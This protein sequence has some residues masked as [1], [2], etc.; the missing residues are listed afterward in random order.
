MTI[1]LRLLWRAGQSESG[2]STMLKNFQLY[3]TPK[4]LQAETDA[5][6]AVIHLN[7][8]RSVNFVLDVL[9]SHTAAA[10]TQPATYN[11]ATGAAAGVGV[12]LGAVT[13]PSAPAGDAGT[14][15]A[16]LRTSAPPAPSSASFSPPPTA[17]GTSEVRRY[18]LE[19]VFGEA[20]TAAFYGV[21]FYDEKNGLG[22]PEWQAGV[23]E[24]SMR[25]RSHAA[26]PNIR[27][28][29]RLVKVA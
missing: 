14:A 23:T 26:K 24:W 29:W 9:S 7:L 4:A 28:T 20:E 18:K 25:I 12:D 13:A 16:A 2:K 27:R 1:L 17:G 6:R 19:R 15:P 11:P 5:W 8:V 21:N 22:G 3:F 10:A